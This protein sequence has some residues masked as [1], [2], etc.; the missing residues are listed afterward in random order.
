MV[1]KK[2]LYDLYNQGIKLYLGGKPATPEAVNKFFNT[3]GNYC[4]PTI[5]YDEKGS[6]KEIYF[7]RVLAANA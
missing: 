3:E 4:M 6:I 7:E 1:V 2:R 5:G